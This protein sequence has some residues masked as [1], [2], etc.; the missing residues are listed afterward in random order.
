[1]DWPVLCLL[2]FFDKI[3]LHLGQDKTDKQMNDEYNQ[4]LTLQ[5]YAIT[6]GAGNTKISPSLQKIFEDFYSQASL[7]VMI[8]N[9]SSTAIFNGGSPDPLVNGDGIFAQIRKREYTQY[10]KSP[11]NTISLKLMWSQEYEPTSVG[12]KLFG[13]KPRV[14]N[15]ECVN[16]ELFAELRLKLSDDSI[17]SL[18]ISDWNQANY[19]IQW[20]E[21]CELFSIYAIDGVIGI[22]SHLNKSPHYGEWVNSNDGFGRSYLLTD[23]ARMFISLFNSL[24]AY[25]EKLILKSMDRL[26]DWEKGRKDDKLDDLKK[27][28][29][30]LIK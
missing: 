12:N 10:Y 28:L 2:L 13:I 24:S 6:G 7:G 18:N 29:L 17:D 15:G 3:F 19:Y 14:I 25:D 5:E 21:I 26:K 8:S 1:M 4:N 23:K 16:I 20:K 11:M 22:Q 27:D 9:P 30:D